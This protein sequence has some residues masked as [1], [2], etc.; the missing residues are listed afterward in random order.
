M[1]PV[2]AWVTRLLVMLAKYVRFDTWQEGERL[3]ILL[4]GYNGRRNTGADLRVAAMVE[5]F[6]HLLGR[7]A[8]EIGVLTLDAASIRGYFPPSVKLE[9][10][11]PMDLLPLLK[12]GSAYHMGVLSEGSCLKSKFANVLTLLFIGFAGAMKRQGKPCLA[13]GSEAGRMDPLIYRT[14]QHL[15]DET[16]FI[17]RSRPSLQI[18]DAMG[19]EGVVGTDTAWIVRPAPA[20]W[21]RRELVRR[22]GWDEERPL[23]GVAVINPF[24]WP[25]KADLVKYLLGGRKKAPLTH[26][27]GWYFLQDSDERRA[28]FHRYLSNIAE[29]VNAWTERHHAHVVLFGMEA[30]DEDACV[31]LQRRLSTPAPI[32]SAVHY[33]GYQLTALLRELSL[34]I[35]SRYHA[36]VLAMPAGV[37]SIA[38]SMDERLRNLLAEAGH[39]KDYYVEAGDPQLSPRL[40]AALETLW[41]NREEVREEMLAAIPHYLHMVAD[42]GRVFRDFVDA[43]FPQFPLPPLGPDWRDYL[44]GGF[45]LS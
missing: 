5:Q 44:P 31:R 34:L 12:I 24:W 17:A 22:A 10:F 40:L 29:A 13:Y 25:V 9:V 16:L 11:D 30:L 19:L 4:I 7:D 2:V 8:V 36:R 3:K 45:S 43:A 27:A 32:F 35:T 21:A 14:A 15:C 6:Y 41:A 33:D 18:I 26:Y 1:D 37:P 38:V 28:L 20:S 23:L 39:L 42:M